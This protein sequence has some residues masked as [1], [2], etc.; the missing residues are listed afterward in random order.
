MGET[1]RKGGLPGGGGRSGWVLKDRENQGDGFQSPGRDWPGSETGRARGRDQAG[2]A[3]CGRGWEGPQRVQLLSWSW[4]TRKVVV[5]CP[6]ASERSW[7]ELSVG[8][9]LREA[10]PLRGHYGL[11]GSPSGHG[12]ASWGSGQS[13]FDPPTHTSSALCLPGL[14]GSDQRQP[15]L[16]CTDCRPSGRHDRT[17][18]ASRILEWRG[19]YRHVQPHVHLFTRLHI[20]HPPCQALSCALLLSL[21]P[22]PSWPPD[23]CS[24]GASLHSPVPWRGGPLLTS[25]Y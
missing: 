18:A 7:T 23:M 16:Y 1:E 19:C 17:E 5:H 20:V 11:A 22:P 25:F 9:G 2:R 12:A 8:P 6:G 13:W 3:G 14:A 15:I 24:V 4:G 21:Q 10:P